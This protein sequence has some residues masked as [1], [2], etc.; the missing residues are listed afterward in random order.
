VAAISEFNGSKKM[1]LAAG[2]LRSFRA[3]CGGT[4]RVERKGVAISPKTAELLEVGIGDPILV[5][6]R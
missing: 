5:V 6:Q 3:C 2:R 4:K 1:I